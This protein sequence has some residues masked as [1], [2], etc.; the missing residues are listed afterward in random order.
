[1]DYQYKEVDLEGLEVLDAISGA[2]KFNR[3]MYDTISPY[4]HGEI[5]EIGSG[6]GNISK[7]FVENN[8]NIHLSDIRDNYIEYLK[9]KLNLSDDRVSKID[10]AD[11]DFEK[12]YPQLLGRFDSVFCLNVVEH[13]EDHQLAVQ[14]ILKMLKP[15]GQAVILVP[16]HQRLFNKID[17]SLQHYRRYTKKSLLEIV[18]PTAKVHNTFYF[19]LM[20]IP[21]WF[22]GGKLF[23]QDSIE[24]GEMKLFDTFVPV[25]KILDK[26]V[27]KSLGLSVITVI[28]PNK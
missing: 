1:M 5:L 3:W 6:L 28:S 27:A 20:G 7:F 15:Y 19:N 9:S 26:A 21:A 16:A 22:V 23:Q 18:P 12:N 14:N 4:C 13:I 17:V 24:K 10:I 11:K 25:W 8:R 2:H